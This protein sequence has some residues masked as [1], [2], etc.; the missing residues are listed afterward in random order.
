MARS[1]DS[2]FRGDQPSSQVRR[3]LDALDRELVNL[4]PPPV[5]PSTRTVILGPPKEAKK[6][7]RALDRDEQARRTDET[8][9]QSPLG[10]DRI[11]E[12]RRLVADLR[13]EVAR[14]HNKDAL[15]PKW[16]RISKVVDEIAAHQE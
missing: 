5:E 3:A 11:V 7:G 12:A 2:A 9:L 4:Q 1:V 10:V 13:R 16:Q 8:H 14:G 15:L 6:A